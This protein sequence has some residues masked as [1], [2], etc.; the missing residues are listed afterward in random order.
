MINIF[1]RIAEDTKNNFEFVICIAAN[2]H[3]SVPRSIGA[4]MLVYSDGKIF[5]TIGGGRIE[6]KVIED[7]LTVLNSKKPAL[8]Q[9]DLHKQLQM[10]CGGSMD[11]YF[12][13]VIKKIN[14]TFLVQGTLVA[15]LLDG[16]LILIFK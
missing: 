5:G 11:V 16:L 15:R 13:P 1:E 12:E 2:T 3:G 8:I 7:A 9:Y 6:K 10:S 14:Y 4:K